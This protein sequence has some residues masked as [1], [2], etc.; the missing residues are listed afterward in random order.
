MQM[1]LCTVGACLD[2]SMPFDAHSAS[3]H[4]VAVPADYLSDSTF[5]RCEHAASAPSA[6]VDCQHGQEDEPAAWSPAAQLRE[7][8]TVDAYQRSVQ[9]LQRT[10]QVMNARLR[11]E[12]AKSKLLSQRIQQLQNDHDVDRL[13]QTLALT[14]IA[15]K[16]VTQR[17]RVVR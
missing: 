9:D 5:G 1:L 12:E 3:P 8:A 17:I 11:S 4:T 14:S 2:A 10:V 15:A 7:N 16:P 13:L 6:E